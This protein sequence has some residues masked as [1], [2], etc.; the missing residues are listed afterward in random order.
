MTLAMTTGHSARQVFDLPEPAPLL[1]TEHR[2]HNCR[3]PGCGAQTQSSFPDD[4]N[5]PAQYGPRMLPEDRL[6]DA[7]ADLFGVKL[8]TATTARMSRNCAA[9]L[10]YL[11]S[12]RSRSPSS[13][14]SS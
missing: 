3:C 11:P 7:M 1:V 12:R 2:A 8:V 4:V 5:A 13:P 14:S 9:G 6:A 10:Q